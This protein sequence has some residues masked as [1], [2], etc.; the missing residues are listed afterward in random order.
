[1]LDFFKT[2]LD[3]QRPTE[4]S[5]SGQDESELAAACLL[6]EAAAMDGD[7]DP[8]ERRRI[9]E[10]LRERFQLPADEADGLLD[11]AEAQAAES[12]EWHGFTNTIKNTF[13][14]E[15]RIKLIEMLWEVAYA[16]GELHDYEASLLRR[17]GGLIYVSDRDRGEAHNR[18]RARL[19]LD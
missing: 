11:A 3:G 9:L 5:A 19:G 1:M 4:S 2:L 17:V 18:V 13:S 12:V 10:L 14:E 15:E 16:D 7:I 6:V 8:A